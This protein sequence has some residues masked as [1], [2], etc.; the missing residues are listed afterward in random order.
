MIG[1]FSHPTVKGQ[2]SEL[3]FEQ[4]N[5]DKT[6]TS[7]MI[8]SIVQDN[9][10][11]IWLGTEIGLLRYDGNQFVRYTR[12]Q[13]VEGSI[14]N[15]RVNVIFEDSEGNLWIGT[16]NGVNHYD[17]NTKLFT[18]IDILPIKG[19]RNYITSFVEDNKKNIWV[20]TFWRSKIAQQGEEI[21][22]K[23]SS[24]LKHQFIYGYKGT[25]FVVR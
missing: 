1:I 21:I 18:P 10:G 24:G 2:S 13:N 7:S 17:K 5:I 23:C 8:S 4:I 16:S 12:D 15:N 20:G 19:G 3:F 14:N 25:F 22:G 9:T 6:H 11:F